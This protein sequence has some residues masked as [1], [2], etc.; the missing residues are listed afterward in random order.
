MVEMFYALAF[1]TLQS[2]LLAVWLSDETITSSIGLN[3]QVPLCPGETFRGYNPGY[4]SMFSS[5]VPE[6]R[7]STYDHMDR[8]REKGKISLEE[9]CYTLLSKGITVAKDITL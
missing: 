5:A 3:M 1:Q 9:S 4:R 2:K 6:I 8:M 7:A